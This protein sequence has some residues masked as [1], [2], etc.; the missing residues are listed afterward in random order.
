MNSR[1]SFPA[2][3]SFSV[4]LAACS[5]LSACDNS[6]QSA[7]PGYEAKVK[8]GVVALAAEAPDGTRLWAVT[9]P[10]AFRRVYFSSA[11]THTDHAEACGKNC[12]RTV[13]DEV[14]AAVPLQQ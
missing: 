14:P 10:G 7:D 6:A 3:R 13:V 1:S 9:P 5:A 8:G 2:R 12:T 4:V 11:G